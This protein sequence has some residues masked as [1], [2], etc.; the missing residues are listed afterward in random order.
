HG[1]HPLQALAVPYDLGRP[2]GVS[3]NGGAQEQLVADLQQRVVD[4]AIEKVPHTPPLSIG[5]AAATRQRGEHAAVAIR[6]EKERAERLEQNS[7]EPIVDGPHRSLA[8]N[9]AIVR[10]QAEPTV[11]TQILASHCV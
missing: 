4:L 8:E 7:L 2:L 6:S 1:V 10:R 5:Q 3:R 11:F 9:P